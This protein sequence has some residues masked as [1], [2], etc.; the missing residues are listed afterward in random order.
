[1]K[2]S[3]RAGNGP[4]LVSKACLCFYDVYEYHRIDFSF[5]FWAVKVEEILG[6]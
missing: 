5:G 3:N 2:F 1:M 4:R 6:F